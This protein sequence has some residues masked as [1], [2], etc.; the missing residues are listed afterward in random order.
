MAL[1]FCSLSSGSSGNCYLV[2]SEKTNILVDAGISARKIGESL[3]DVGLTMDEI[4]AVLV[5]HEH[6]DHIR[7][8]DTMVKKYGIPVYTNEGT[9]E[10]MIPLCKNSD[11]IDFRLFCQGTPFE[12]GD[13]S[14]EAFNVSHDAADTVGF[15]VKSGGSSLCTATDTGCVTPEIHRALCESDL[16]VIE[17]NHDED[18]LRMGKYP[19]FLKQRILSSH[20][21]LS[22]EA[23]GEEIVRTMVDSPK[24]RKFLL[25]HLSR[26]NNFPEMAYQ[27]IV[28]VL[29]RNSLYLGRSIKI[30]LLHRDRRSRIYRV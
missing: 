19:W 30:E 21:H 18:V 17:A 29:E 9:R 28:N 24:D 13:L 6:V 16:V 22:N 15:L 14:V 23:A 25:A 2:G 7:G 11:I 4:S 12:V 3:N 5:T 20:G 8:I 1:K 26:E 27:T 10:A